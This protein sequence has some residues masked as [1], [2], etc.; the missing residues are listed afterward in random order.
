MIKKWYLSTP[1][2]GKT[3][4][5]IQAALQRGIDWA[6]NRGEYYHNPYNPANAKFTEGKIL[7]PKPIKMLSKAIAPMDSCDGVLF[8]GSY[9]EL[10]KSRGCQVEINIADVYGLE[11]LT[12]D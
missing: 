4:E 6:N 3:E 1:I 9:E 2:N 5:E 12:I 8:I 11:V 7:D 10:R